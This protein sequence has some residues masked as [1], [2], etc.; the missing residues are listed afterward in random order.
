MWSK[1]K[2]ITNS[3]ST[4]ETLTYSKLGGEG[5]V[6]IKRGLLEITLSR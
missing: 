4:I 5:E 3:I 2:V 6:I 1:K